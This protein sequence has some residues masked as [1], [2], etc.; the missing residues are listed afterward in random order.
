MTTQFEIVAQH[1]VDT[2]SEKFMKQL[3]NAPDYI[4]K[5]TTFSSIFQEISDLKFELELEL[6]SDKCSKSCEELHKETLIRLDSLKEQ[7]E[8]FEQF[9]IRNKI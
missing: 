8:F 3:D 7:Y 5:L 4:S 6:A 9:S 1:S 2:L